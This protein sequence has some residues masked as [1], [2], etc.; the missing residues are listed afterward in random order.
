[1]HNKYNEDDE[2]KEQDDEQIAAELSDSVLTM[3][4]LGPISNMIEAKV[5]IEGL[6]YQEGRSQIEILS[7][8]RMKMYMPTEIARI[9]MEDIRV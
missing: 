9:S 1:M 3:A 5:T 6:K 2:N 8:G 7:D 4:G